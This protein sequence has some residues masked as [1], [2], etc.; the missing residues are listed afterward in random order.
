MAIQHFKHTL[1]W[2][3]KHRFSLLTVALILVLV[4]PAFASGGLLEE[5]LFLG[6]M[7]FLLAQ[8]MIVATDKKSKYPVIRYLIV[9]LMV[10]FIWTEPIGVKVMK[11][12]V[13]RLILLSTFF[14]FVTFYLARF[15]I[16][17]KKVNHDVILVAMNIYLLTG[18]I[19]GNLAFL[20]Y[21][22]LPGAYHFPEHIKEPTF[23]TFNYY[24]FITMSTVG[25]GD[26]IPILPQTQTL[27]FLIAVTGQLYVA[28]IIA[29]MVGKFLMNPEQH[30]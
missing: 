29:F 6:S 8:S 24:S 26:I 21:Q 17:A 9:I 18:I 7:S 27:G 28:V 23:V 5:I 4:L 16:R 19:A 14:V 12:E 1:K 10:L 15:M 30:K 22:T 11:V 20:L 25:Y 2:I 13:I 3:E